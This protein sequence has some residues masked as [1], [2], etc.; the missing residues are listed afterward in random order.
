MSLLEHPDAQALLNDATVSA[1]SVRDCTHR[2]TDFLQRYLPRF[3]R[4]E[5]RDNATTVI[6]GLLGG[7]QRKTCEPIAVEAGVHRKPIQN[8][9]GG[10]KWDD[11][12]VQKIGALFP[13][14]RT[15]GVS[16]RA[17]LS[18]G[19]AS[20]PESKERYRRKKIFSDRGSLGC[21]R[22]DT[23]DCRAI[24]LRSR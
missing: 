8:F 4:A 9:V 12:A 17:I 24:S 15:V 16:A 10:G 6:R 22:D 11:E 19:G 2:L 21:A 7:L 23:F 1:D 3:Y 13:G 14:R 18:G 20:P 5:Q